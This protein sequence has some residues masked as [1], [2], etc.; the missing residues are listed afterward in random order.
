MYYEVKRYKFSFYRILIVEDDKEIAEVLK[1]LIGSKI[2]VNGE[3]KE[4]QSTTVYT[5][6]DAVREIN[7]HFY[8]IVLLD[9]SIPY[10]DGES[11]LKRYGFEMLDLVK[12]NNMTTE[13]VV[14]T[15]STDL[16]DAEMSVKKHAFY[17]LQK[18]Y[19]A[20]FIITLLQRII[21]YQEHAVMAVKDGLTGLYNY[22]FFHVMLEKEIQAHMISQH[23]KRRKTKEF[24]VIT[25]DLDDFRNVNNTYNHEAGNIVL[26]GVAKVL[27]RRFRLRTQDIVARTGGEEFSV[28]LPDAD[29]DIALQLAHRLR[30][31][32][33]QEKFIYDGKTIAMTMTIGVAT[34]PSLYLGS[35]EYIFKFADNALV[36]GKKRSK[37]CIVS[38][39]QSGDYIMYKEK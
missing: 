15:G 39:D 14:I 13:V 37:D 2:V 8:D 38:Y 24:S 16:D 7:E 30:D 18:P 10:L 17:Y 27:E 6:S 1:Q 28:L 5:F 3:T 4:I 33:R 19:R 20:T 9:L 35:P 29:N 36:Y 22:G 11:P 23:E 32:I 12:K 25:M 34:Y 21:S 26:V 31:Q